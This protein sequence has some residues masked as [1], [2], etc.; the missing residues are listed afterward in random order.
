MGLAGGKLYSTFAEK[1]YIFLELQLCLC[2]LITGLV[3]ITWGLSKFVNMLQKKLPVGPLRCIS[4]IQ[5]GC[6]KQGSPNFLA[7]GQL[8]FLQALGGPNCDH[9]G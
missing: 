4:K 2:I 7:M 1:N 9:C 6:I 3:G 5:N 8:T